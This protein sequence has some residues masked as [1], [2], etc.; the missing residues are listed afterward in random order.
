MAGF[1]QPETPRDQLTLWTQRLDDAIPVDHPVRHLD[2]LLQSGALSETFATWERQYVLV[3][4]KPPYHPRVLAG[5]Y[6]Y[7]MLNGIR[8]S[9]QLE[10][11]CYNRIDVRWLMSGQCP[12][13]STIAAF[14]SQHLERLRA[15][16][17]DILG[18]GIRAKLIKTKHVAVDGTKIEAD[19]GKGSVHSEETIAE[20]LSRLDEQ[21][22]ALESAWQ[23]NEQRESHLFGDAVAW[24]PT[25]SGTD[26]QRLAR[27]K[28]QQTRLGEALAAIAR[29]RSESA[30]RKPTKAICSVTDPDSRVMP[31][32]EGKRKPN[33]NAQLAVDAESGGILAG[34]VNDEADDSGQLTPMLRQVASNCGGLPEAVSADSGYNTGPELAA[35][36]E[37]GVVG[38][39]PDSGEQSGLKSSDTP[40]AQAMAAAQASEPL[41]AAQWEALPKDSKGRITKASF[42]YDR[43]ADVVRCPMGAVLG[44]EGSGQRA[45][46]WGTAIRRRYGGSPGCARCPRSS[47]CCAKP[48]RGRTVH[49]DQYESHRERM[50]AR[51][52]SEA[53]R[54]RYR[55]R[56]QTVEPRFGQIK[57]GLGLRRFLRRGLSGVRA[58][59]LVACTA[60]N[61]GILLRH[62]R[63]VQAAL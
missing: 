11:A 9:R 3:E 32:K 61:V 31:D 41:S 29:R 12:D 63:E 49:R 17:K 6:V 43:R 34:D 51:M 46:K 38:Y 44:F 7:G 52:S 42:R 16:M 39:L 53:G 59:W 58:E 47:S 8:S 36:E 25:G 48:V 19:A 23:A 22:A 2:Y 18:V 45:M 14:V 1:R 20:A 26:A 54:S 27:M 24:T 10:A 56:R 21:I 35:L 5:L 60:V 15:L 33:Y 50:R 37:D 28:R 4:G 57:R 55:L 40:E 13:H 62:W 30:G